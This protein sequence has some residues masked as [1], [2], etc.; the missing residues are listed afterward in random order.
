M[1]PLL[2]APASS[3]CYC[4]ALPVVVLYMDVHSHRN[5]ASGN[6]MKVESSKSSTYFCAVFRPQI[7]PRDDAVNQPRRRLPGYVSPRPKR[8]F[9]TYQ[10][11][12]SSARRL[13]VPLTRGI[14]RDVLTE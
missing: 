14:G 7:Q 12:I 3:P 4:L 2:N 9:L 10:A 11:E 6:E 5:A 1:S 8:T 13:V